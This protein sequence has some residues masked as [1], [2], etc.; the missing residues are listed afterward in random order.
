MF[1]WF[2]VQ[3]HMIIEGR[4]GGGYLGIKIRNGLDSMASHSH[5]QLLLLRFLKLCRSLVQDP[6]KA[7][8]H[9]G[10]VIT[11]AS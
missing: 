2:Q 10:W 8:V 5:L 1:T 11:M 3:P 4:K 7:D 6:P 9:P